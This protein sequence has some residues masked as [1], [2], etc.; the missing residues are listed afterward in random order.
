MVEKWAHY[1]DMGHITYLGIYEAS[2]IQSQG[3]VNGDQLKRRIISCVTV[4][5]PQC[6]N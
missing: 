6:T 1:V 2:R 3:D 5:A 4:T